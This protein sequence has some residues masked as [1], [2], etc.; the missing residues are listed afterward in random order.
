MPSDLADDHRHRV[1]GELPL[2]D[3]EP[4]DRLDQPDRPDL[5][6]V[7]DLLAVP[8]EPAGERADEREV[9]LDQSLARPEIA[10]GVIRGEQVPIPA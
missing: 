5:D 3:A 8:G 2:P 9:L 1:A 7:V 10:P 6:E 4:V